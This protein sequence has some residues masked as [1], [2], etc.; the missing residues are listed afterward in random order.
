MLKIENVFKTKM[1]MNHMT[2]TF[3]DIR[4]I[5]LYEYL[6]FEIIFMEGYTTSN[7]FSQTFLWHSFC[8]IWW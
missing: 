1:N 5:Q 3:E 2:K 8:A 7:L 6:C 4:T